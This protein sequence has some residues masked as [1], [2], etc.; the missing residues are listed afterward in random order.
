MNTTELIEWAETHQ[1]VHRTRIVEIDADI[2]RP[3]FD[4]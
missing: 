3:L 2:I 4:A 1:I